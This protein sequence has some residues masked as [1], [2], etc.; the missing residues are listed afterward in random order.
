MMMKKLMIAGASAFLLSAPAVADDCWMT[1]H[2]PTGCSVNTDRNYG[3]IRDRVLGPPGDAEGVKNIMIC[4]R[5]NDGTVTG[6]KLQFVKVGDS[7]LIGRSAPKDGLEVVNVVQIDRVKR[8]LLFISNRIGS[9]LD[10][11]GL[12][13]ADVLP[14]PHR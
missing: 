3:F 10:R 12:F 6:A 9:A 8:K 4:F 2:K 5:E 1:N 13:T 14:V 11:A 7:T